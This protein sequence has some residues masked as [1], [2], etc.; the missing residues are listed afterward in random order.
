M[1]AAMS[2]FATKPEHANYGSAVVVV[3]THGEH[4]RL[5]GSDGGEVFWYFVMFLVVDLGEKYR[6]AEDSSD[7]AVSI[8][9]L[10]IFKTT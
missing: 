9:Y 10:V 7:M 8:N 2:R 4:G 5:Y 6:F 3:L 1:L